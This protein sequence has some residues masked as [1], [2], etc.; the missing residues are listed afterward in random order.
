MFVDLPKFIQILLSVTLVQI[1]VNSKILV[2]D[3]H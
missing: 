2:Q 3:L 1:R